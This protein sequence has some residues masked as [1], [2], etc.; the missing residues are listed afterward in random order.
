MSDIDDLS[1]LQVLAR[2]IWG[3]ARSEPLAGKQAVAS[4]IMNRAKHPSWWGKNVR[5]CC[6]KPY[7]FSAWNLGDPN[8]SK[9]MAVTAEDK[10]FRDC[11]S[12]ANSAIAGDLLDNSGGSDSYQVVGTNAYWSKGLTPVVTIG[13]HE[14][15]KTVK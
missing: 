4:I 2:T 15:F 3:E 5:S 9:L 6:L 10:S 7:Q 8:R 11:V 13:K 14:F 1:D 12:I